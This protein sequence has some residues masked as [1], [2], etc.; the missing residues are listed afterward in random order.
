MRRASSSTSGESG[1][2]TSVECGLQDGKLLGRDL[3]LGVAEE[4]GV[5][6]PDGGQHGHARGEDVGRVE[7]AAETG[8]DHAHLDAGGRE[9]DERGRRVGLELGDRLALVERAV[10]GLDRLGDALDRRGERLGRDLGAVDL[11]ALAP[12]LVVRREVR[13]GAHAVCL[14]QRRHDLRHRGLAVGADDV[15]RLEAVLGHAEHRH[16]LRMRSSPNRIPAAR[17][18]RGTPRLG[19]RSTRR[20]ASAEL[21]ELGPVALELGALRLDDL[22]GRLGDKALVGELALAT[23][24]LGLELRAALGEP[25]P[26]RPPVSTSADSSTSTG[27][28]VVSGSPPSASKSSRASRAT[29]SCGASPLARAA[30]TL[31]AAT[32][33][34]SRQRRT[35]G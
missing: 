24:D 12:A 15:D 32:P 29:N 16:Q 26:R 8:L 31:A 9:G 14:E 2:I 21:G 18:T 34:S 4:L 22:G 19:P 11:N 35:S 13:A 25:L 5:L 27:P 1:P 28:I 23:L 6:E 17:A 30:S 20:S 10:D 7:A 3:E 33:L